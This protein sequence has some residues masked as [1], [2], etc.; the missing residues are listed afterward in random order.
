MANLSNRIKVLRL[1]AQM[2][3]EEFGQKFGIV[4]S[5]VSLYESGKSTPN[6]HEF[7]FQFKERL[8]EILSEENISKENFMETTG[9]SKEETDAYFSGNKVPSLEGLCTIAKV[10]NI[11]SDYLLGISNQK[12][13]SSE[14]KNLLQKFN[15]CDEESQQY[16]LAKA[17]VLCVER[18]SAISNNECGKYLDQEK[19]LSLSNGINKRRA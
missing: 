14:E 1:S 8:Q 16:L 13:I 7:T 6:D 19:K 3:Q 17:G 2:T 10:L 18:I 11:S 5:T 15:R 4:K 12:Q 9:F